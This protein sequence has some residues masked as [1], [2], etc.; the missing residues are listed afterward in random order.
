M[1]TPESTDSDSELQFNLL[2]I[3]NK[4]YLCKK[5]ST[6]KNVSEFYSSCLTRCK[7]CKSAYQVERARLKKIKPTC[8][9][10]PAIEY[11]TYKGPDTNKDYIGNT[12]TNI[13]V[14]TESYAHNNDWYVSVKL[15]DYTKLLD[16]YK[17]HN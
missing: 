12:V 7:T 8:F 1:N 13:T 16:S 15:S 9:V 5:C 6:R 2:K 4:Q 10:P 3:D 14:P 11:A 17:M